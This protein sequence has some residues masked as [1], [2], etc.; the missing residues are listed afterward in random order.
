MPTL[1]FSHKSLPQALYSSKKLTNI[2]ILTKK[3]NTY[4]YITNQKCTYAQSERAI[5]L[6]CQGSFRRLVTF[7]GKQEKYDHQK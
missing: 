1:L 7:L 6:V 3:L 2:P 5:N 4:K